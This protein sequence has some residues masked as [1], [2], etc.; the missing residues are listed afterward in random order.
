MSHRTKIRVLTAGIAITVAMASLVAARDTH[1]PDEWLQKMSS[2]IQTLD[3]E[4]TVIRRQNGEVQPL[5]VVHKK[6]DGI[7]NERIVVQEGNGLE[8]IRVGDEVH[9]ILPDKQTVL[10][11]TWENTSTL[12]A[13]LPSS[14]VEPGAQYDVLIISVDERVAGRNAVKLAIKP[15]DS[16]RFEHHFWLDKKTG[17][18]LRADMI[19]Q[20]GQVVDQLKFADISIGQNVM[21]RALAPSVSLQNYTWYTNAGSMAHEEIESDWT[22]DSLPPGFRL[23]SAKH[24]VLSGSEIEVLHLVFGDGIAS[25]SVFISEMGDKQLNRNEL[26]GAS[27]SYSTEIDGHQITAVGEVPPQTVEAIAT[28]MQRR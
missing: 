11:E 27:S 6:V 15:N 18:P 17:F 12:F 7:V 22:N 5:K 10:V 19:D 4:G 25:V 23:L 2:A 24:D 28:S 13:T 26:R 16:H 14:P 21:Q 1:T 9:C 3:Y 8:I 20:N